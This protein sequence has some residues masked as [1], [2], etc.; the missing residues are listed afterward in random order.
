MVM[1]LFNYLMAIWA[2]GITCTLDA[3]WL[4]YY[5][6]DVIYS[7]V[8]LTHETV[9]RIHEKYGPAYLAYHEPIGRQRG[10]EGYFRIELPLQ[11]VRSLSVVPA[12]LSR[13]G[14]LVSV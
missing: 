14:A 6:A 1:L 13:P 11:S 5:D 10:E 9:A 12:L 8:P 3:E 2:W 4:W 7:F